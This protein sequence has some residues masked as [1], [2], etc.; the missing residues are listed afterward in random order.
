MDDIV[1]ERIVEDPKEFC[2]CIMVCDEHNDILADTTE[3]LEGKR[4]KITIE[5]IE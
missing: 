2:G 1:I 3:K 4:V 5:V